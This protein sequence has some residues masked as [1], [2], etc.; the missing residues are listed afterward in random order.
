MR[1][2]RNIIFFVLYCLTIWITYFV[3]LFFFIII[4]FFFFFSFSW[5]TG[6]PTN[7]WIWLLNHGA[8]SP[9]GSYSN[10]GIL[11]GIN[12]GLLR[13]SIGTPFHDSLFNCSS[14]I[15]T[16]TWHHIVVTRSNSIVTGYLDGSVECVGASS[17]SIGN[18]NGLLIGHGPGPN[19]I[20]S[21][22]LIDSV[23]VWPRAI[24]STEAVT[25]YTGPNDNCFVLNGGICGLVNG[26]Q[27][28]C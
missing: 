4:L 26:I 20:S 8:Y 12:G 6:S 22:I 18:T 24:T 27:T 21:S 23:Y 17:S 1:M 5:F 10:S 3:F 25:L 15:T 16:N 13:V 7:G 28:G 19:D 14:I 9:S 2:E 11:I